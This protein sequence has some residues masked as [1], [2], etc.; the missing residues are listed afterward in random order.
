[1]RFPSSFLDE[2]RSRLLPS[3][4]I[5]KKV[6][7]QH[8][9][10]E[11]KGLCPFH[12]ENTPSFTVSDEK[13]FYHCFGCGAHGDIIKFA[14]ETEGLHYVEAVKSLAQQAGM[15]L[16]VMSP[17][18]QQKERQRK[19]ISQ[20]M[21]LA[22]QWFITQLHSNNGAQARHYLQKRGLTP[23]II[24]QFKLGFAPD[25]RTALLNHMRAHHVE[26]AL[27]V[28]AGLARKRDGNAAYDYFR[29]RIMFP[30]C[31]AR[32]S[33]IAFGGRALGDEQPKYLNSPDT[34]L[35]KKGDV[36]YNEHLARGLA[37]KT[38]KLVIVEGYMD[39]IALYKAGIKTAVS[40]LGTA[41]TPHQLSR[42]WSMA[43][44]PVMCFDGDNA[45]QRAMERAANTALP[46]LN[47]GKT[48]QF[49]LLPKGKDPDDMVRHYGVDHMRR[50]LQSAQPLSQ[51]MWDAEKQ[52]KSLHTP[53]ALADLE[54]RLGELAQKIS[55]STVQN[56]YR[57]FFRNQLWQLRRNTTLTK[58]PVQN[59]LL[60]K[61]T[62]IQE[63]F[64][65][66]QNLEDS[67][68]AL[69]IA[70]LHAPSL[71]SQ[72][73]IY[74]EFVSV[75]FSTEWL[76]STRTAILDAFGEDDSISAENLRLHL[77][78]T[79]IHRYISL[80][81]RIALPFFSD[82]AHHSSH[83]VKGWELLFKQFTLA[84]LKQQSQHFLKADNASYE[85]LSEYRKQM[86]QLV[87]QIQEIESTCGVETI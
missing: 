77:E 13:G 61:E 38:G 69:V 26:E 27:L 31:N 78:K 53:E 55:N 68:K 1:M 23:Q 17:Q 30:I 52:R 87:S 70:I 81:D 85:K 59:R 3:E 22:C 45:G 14:C 47:P 42:L 16:P 75:D 18:Q 32:G 43:S 86:D 60:A 41:I 58:A 84:H 79:D 56:H 25:S 50:L 40:P 71:L 11:H 66:G 35:F 28:E 63:N 2:L 4:V 7:L 72:D 48:L 64:S 57:Q 37:F 83:T 39:A 67:E 51:I 29:G 80:L 49:T 15:E 76:D 73:H 44:E 21:E 46:L 24:E 62:R 65:L 54:H 10:R 5:K 33:V 12:K 9:G 8:N 82:E 34:P 20:V 6:Q 36:L 74:E 19:T